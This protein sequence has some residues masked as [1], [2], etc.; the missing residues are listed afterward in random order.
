MTENIMKNR[1]IILII[2]PI[3]F[4]IDGVNCKNDKNIMS[5]LKESNVIY[6]GGNN[7]VNLFKFS[8][9]DSKIYFSYPIVK[10]NVNLYT[11]Q[12]FDVKSKKYREIFTAPTPNNIS[13]N[14]NLGVYSE[15]I[16]VV[17]SVLV[18]IDSYNNIK[19]FYELN[20]ERIKEIKEFKSYQ[21]LSYSQQSKHDENRYLFYDQDNFYII[22]YP[23][24]IKKY[25]YPVKIINSCESIPVISFGRSASEI[26]FSFYDKNKKNNLIFYNF[27]KNT[28]TFKIII[29]KNIIQEEYF[30]RICISPDSKWI[31]LS[32][33][34]RGLWLINIKNCEIMDF[35]FNDLE[36]LSIVIDDWSWDSGRIIVRYGYAAYL[37]KINDIIKYKKNSGK[38]VKVEQW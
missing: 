8:N 32:I 19:R 5:L 33:E 15:N 29:P 14:D 12:E 10:K 13:S 38:I 35:S 3:L 11:I 2:L 26:I 24:K 4:I 36:R 25:N 28:I 17:N 30:S 27:V 34:N 18:I 7:D 1:K 21:Q 9:D 31:I 22:E 20:L 23:N 16:F 6:N 37:V